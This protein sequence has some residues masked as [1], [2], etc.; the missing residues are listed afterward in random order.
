KGGGKIENLKNKKRISQ[1][2][3]YKYNPGELILWKISGKE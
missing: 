2:C 1:V 3:K